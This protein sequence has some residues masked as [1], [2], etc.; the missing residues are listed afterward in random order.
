LDLPPPPA[1][2]PPAPSPPLPLARRFYVHRDPFINSILTNAVMLKELRGALRSMKFM[3]VVLGTVVAGSA[4]LLFTLRTAESVEAGFG[5]R[6][7]MSLYIV[8]AI[9]I[10]IAIP[11]YASVAIA[12]ER[13]QRT[14]DLLITTALRP[15]EIIW[16]K[17]AA[18]MVLIGIFI[19][20]CMP[21]V[22]ICFLY[23]ATD[24][25]TVAISYTNLLGSAA[26][27]TLFCLLLSAGAGNPTTTIMTACALTPISYLPFVPCLFLSGIGGSAGLMMLPWYLVSAWSF[28][29][30]CGL[31]LGIASSMLVPRRHRALGSNNLL[32]PISLGVLVFSCVCASSFVAGAGAPAIFIALLRL[33][34]HDRKQHA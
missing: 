22:F 34:M 26:A 8:Q 6:M 18:I 30:L 14:L 20:A 21:L 24:P 13:Q 11:A 31:F 33:I 28:A 16:G 4:I 15:W 29:L 3:L 10:G 12:G 25:F 1:L 7:F 27:A 9:C 5:Y 19:I 2:P 23:G 32:I 17:F